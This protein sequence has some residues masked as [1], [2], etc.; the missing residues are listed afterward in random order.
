[1]NPASSLLI[2]NLQEI[3]SIVHD[4]NR[5]IIA[6]PIGKHIYNA[7]YGWGKFWK[8]FF[9]VYDFFF[10]QNFKIRKIKE[11]LHATDKIFNKSI[12][13]AQNHLNLFEQQ[14]IKCIEDHE[15]FSQKKYSKEQ[16]I[17]TRWNDSTKVFLDTI[18][19]KK[20]ENFQSLLERYRIDDQKKFDTSQFADTFSKYQSIIN[21]ERQ[22]QTPTPLKILNKLSQKKNITKNEEGEITR[23]IEIINKS[24]RVT[25]GKF[26]KSLS[27][28]ITHISKNHTISGIDP[29]N[30]SHLEL[31]L[32]KRNI[33][34][35]RKKDDKHIT[36]RKSLRPGSSLEYKGSYI[37][38][39]NEIKSN[40]R[41]NNNNIIY[42]IENDPKHVIIIGKN[43]A[44]L[45]IKHLIVNNYSWG[46]WATKW[47]YVDTS[48]DYGII[49]RLEK[50]LTENSWSSGINLDKNDKLILRPIKNQI[51]WLVKVN[52]TP[53]NFNF[54]NF[55]Y[56]K[57][58]I[59]KCSKPTIVGEFDFPALVNFAKDC[60]K[61]NFKVFEYLMKESGLLKHKYVR[62][63]QE[64]AEKTVENESIDVSDLAAFQSY[65]ILDLKVIDQA[66][67][68][69]KD[70]G[71]LQ[72]K[73]M[74]KLMKMY[75]IDDIIDIANEIKINFKKYYKFDKSVCFLWPELKKRIVSKII[76]DKNLLLKEE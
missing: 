17:I 40:K 3:Y 12:Q 29:A 32:T 20:K 28:L 62:Y 4:D 56:N 35:F 13:K 72:K 54:K 38:L 68:L 42:N 25:V 21:L 55:M 52:K 69:K 63:F 57:K 39:G 15:S 31:E 23:W 47:K 46:V 64:V 14:L 18:C 73:C 60:S 53:K 36:W 37:T 59:L 19:N 33:T 43:K 51:E 58:G 30:L 65:Q 16:W 2:S 6:A 45:G 34:I 44:I 70:I 9:V 71:S 66:N 24:K 74:D 7:K 67:E 76:R 49:E 26:H 22:L 61:G 48:G 11:A 75:E 5:D 41:T 10:G 1:M 27:A 8:I 50:P